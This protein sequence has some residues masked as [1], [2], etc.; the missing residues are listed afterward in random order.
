[1][2]GTLTITTLSDG[3]NSTSTTNCIQGSAKAWVNFNGTGA[4][5][6]FQTIRSNYNV[7]SVFK[8]ATGDYTINFASSLSDA[9]YAFVGSTG[10]TGTV[11]AKES[12][13]APTTSA[14][15]IR[16]SIPSVGFNDPD[17]VCVSIYR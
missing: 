7:S 2:P 17:Y 12:T 15:R 11:V 8:N 13:V 10:T 9:T 4:V 3:T 5:S 6:T 1:M 16:T 14:L